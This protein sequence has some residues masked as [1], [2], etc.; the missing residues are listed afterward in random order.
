MPCASFLQPREPSSYLE[1][2]MTCLLKNFGIN[3]TPHNSWLAFTTAKQTTNGKPL[4]P[5][6]CF[7]L[8]SNKTN[9]FAASLTNFAGCCVAP[10]EP[11][12]E[13]RE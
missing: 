6:H 7:Y 11:Q 10:K 9:R 5:H 13:Y 8:L 4:F 2:Q 12:A 1:Y 3:C